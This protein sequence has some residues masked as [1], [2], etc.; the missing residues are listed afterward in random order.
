[1][2]VF[3]TVAS[4]ITLA[5][6][7]WKL[8]DDYRKAPER[9][10]RL[11]FDVKSLELIL[12]GLKTTKL[13]SKD[14]R[15]ALEPE[16]VEIEHTLQKILDGVS[17]LTTKTK[18]R[19][20]LSRSVSSL[21]IQRGFGDLDELAKELQN[22]KASLILVLNAVNLNIVAGIDAATVRPGNALLSSG[23]GSTTKQP[24]T[25]DSNPV[26]TSREFLDYLNAPN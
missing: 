23:T 21:R 6:R 1:M 26:I 17:K 11:Q 5:E 25:V 24:G 22:R 9:L 14:Q 8:I 7:V 10:R 3:N 2:E 18:G 15:L 12:E 20:A 13:P 16:I 19:H 4:A